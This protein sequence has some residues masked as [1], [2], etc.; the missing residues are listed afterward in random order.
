VAA[1]VKIVFGTGVGPFPHGTQ[2]KEFEWMV[3]FGMTPASAIRAATSVAADLL[4]WQDRVG[5]I[6]AGKFADVIA[7]SGDPLCGC[8]RTGTG[9]IRDEGRAGS[10]E[11][12]EVAL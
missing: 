11:R 6:E 4:G 2:A 5:S 1:G 9:E 8:H 10:Q 3:K 12:S 7:V